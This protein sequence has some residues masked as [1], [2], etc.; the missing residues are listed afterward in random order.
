MIKKAFSEICTLLLIAVM[1]AISA[2]CIT[3]AEDAIFLRPFILTLRVGDNTFG[4]RAY[5]A[6][7][8]H[9]IFLSLND[10][11][12]AL[13]GTEKQ[14]SI[15]YSRSNQDGEYHD[16]RTGESY[17]EDNNGITPTEYD[18]REDVWLVFCL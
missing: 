11:S 16:I 3:Y 10:L 14:Y 4:L 13:N 1:L 15:V 2:P 17:L 18:Q 8:E 5:H 6:S 9:N 12:Q 7:Y